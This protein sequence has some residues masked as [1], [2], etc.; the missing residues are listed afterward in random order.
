MTESVKVAALPAAVILCYTAI[1][2]FKKTGI[3]GRVKELYPL[4]STIIGVALGVV[5][6]VADSAMGGD[7]LIEW[8]LKGMAGGL[9]ATG[10]DQLIARLK[11]LAPRAQNEE[12]RERR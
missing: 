5:A 3:G 11:N 6:F 7:A 2:L 4:I 12:N 9:S 8:A 10:A 1:E